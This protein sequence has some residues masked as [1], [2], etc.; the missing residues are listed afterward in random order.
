MAAAVGVGAGG[1]LGGLHHHGPQG[2]VEREQG[3]QPLCQSGRVARAHQAPAHDRV[4][5]REICAL[6][7]PAF[8]VEADE[9]G[10][11]GVAAGVGQGGDQPVGAGEHG[12]VGAGHRDLSVD[13]PDLD[14]ADHRQVGAAG[15][16]GQDRGA[17]VVAETAQYFRAG[18]FDPELSMRL[19][20]LRKRLTSRPWAKPRL[21]SEGGVRLPRRAGGTLGRLTDVSDVSGA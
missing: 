4:A 21:A 20:D 19:R 5:E 15:E 7:F 13:D 14:G 2:L 1:G 10:G 18:R 9:R 12:A 3:P 17:P 11:S 16:T 6:V 8:V